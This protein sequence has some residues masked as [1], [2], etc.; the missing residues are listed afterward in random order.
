VTSQP[1]TDPVA[2]LLLDIEGTTT[3]IDFVYKVLFPYARTHVDDYLAAHRSLPE[4]ATLFEENARDAK[5]GLDP[6][7]LEESPQVSIDAVA[8]YVRWLMDQDSKTTALKS[9]QGKI[10]EE[11]YRKG[12]LRSQLFKDV[13]PAFNRWRAHGKMICIYSSGSVLAQRLLFA[14]TEA[15][16]L[17][18][19]ISGYY[20]TN[21]GG[22]KDPESY[23]RIAAGL[24]LE[25]HS[26]L[27]VSDVTDELDAAATAGFQ[28]L[29]CIRP[30][31][32]PQPVPIIHSRID[33]FDEVLP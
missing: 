24:E 16:D 10:W 7:L 26:V 25:A 17:T 21:V 8:S 4:L 22:K 18:P 30:G 11:G 20:D 29:L 2:A 1:L 28:T 5:R 23:S 3:P 6:P 15:G 9:L 19:F 33:S 32:H 14:H 27:F 12:A 31:N 13:P